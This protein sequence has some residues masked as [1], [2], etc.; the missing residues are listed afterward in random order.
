MTGMALDFAKHCKLPFGAYAEGHEEYPQTNTMAPRTR[1]VICLGPT[2]NFQGSYKMMCHKTGRKLTRKQFQELP[3]PESIIKRI[4]AIAEKEKQEK[5]II[6]SNRNEESL[7]DD[8]AVNDNVTAGLDNDDDGDDNTSNNNNPPGILLGELVGNEDEASEGETTGNESTGVLTE[9]Q[10]PTGN[11]SAGVPAESIDITEVQ[12]YESPGVSSDEDSI[13]APGETADDAT[14]EQENT[15]EEPDAASNVSNEEEDEVEPNVAPYDPYIWAPSIQR[16]HGLRPRK[17]R[18]YSHLHATIMHH[19]MPQYSLKKGLKK[20]KEIGEEAV[21]KELLQL[22]MRDTFKPQSADELSTNQ[23]KGALESL[24]FLKEKRDG[25]VKGRTCA[26]RRKQRETAKPGAATSPTVSLESVLITSTI[27]AYEGR[28]VTVVDIPGAYLSADMDEEVI[29]L[30]HGRMAELMV[31]TAPNTYRNYI[32]VD[33]KH[34]P[35]LYVKLQKALYGC[36]RSAL[37]FYLKFVGDIE[38]QG[39]ALNPYDPCVANKVING[40]Q[41]TVVWHVD[42]IKMS[43]V[44]EKEV[45]K[46]IIWLKSIYGEDMRVLRGRVHDY[47]GMTLDFTNKG[48]VKVT[49]I[50]YLKGVI[51]DFPEIITGTAITPATTNLF[52]ARPEY[53]RK[54]LGKEQ[55]RAFHHSVAQLLFATTRAR[56]DI[57][58]TVAFLT[59]RVKSPYE[60]DWMKLKRLLKYIRGTTY[61]PI[62]LKADNLNIVKWWVD[63]SYA[64]HGDCNGHTGATMSM[65]TGSITGISKKQKIN[66]RSSTESEL[67]GVHD[68]APQMLWTRYCIEAQGYKLK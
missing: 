26:D 4:E 18:Q 34:Q 54:V 8:D 61:M 49:M 66:T 56:K 3:M 67:V 41:F 29:I 25:T 27:E 10:E 57:Q 43:H 16:V 63:A 15:D 46:L 37:L 32:T 60:D 21:S 9:E 24:M 44:D 39:F 47:L 6:F 42:D 35:V 38:S 17:A 30:L 14:G 2:G 59:T 53:E 33:A 58:H 22:H 31:K 55:A 62:I 36:L 28:E 20:F 45:S 19:A 64:T 50:D 13:D 1:G 65:G 40:K 48:E 11:E 68:M 23:N 5:N 12:D 51:N 52:D 7:Q